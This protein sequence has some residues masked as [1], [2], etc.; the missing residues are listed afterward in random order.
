MIGSTYNLGVHR[1]CRIQHLR[2]SISPSMV[3]NFTITFIAILIHN[4]FFLNCINILKLLKASYLNIT[5]EEYAK[6][7]QEEVDRPTEHSCK[8]CKAK[9]TEILYTLCMTYTQCTFCRRHLPPRQFEDGDIICRACRRK[10]TREK[11][12]RS[13]FK[14]LVREERIETVRGDSDLP[15]FLTNNTDRLNDILQRGINEHT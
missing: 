15:A 8:N 12:E 1:L 10:T 6:M 4:I 11:S 13:A 7:I 2:F 5:D 14:G 9:T 3:R